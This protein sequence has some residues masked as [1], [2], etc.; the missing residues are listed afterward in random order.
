MTLSSLQSTQKKKTLKGY[1]ITILALTFFYAVICV[2]ISIVTQT[3]AVVIDSM[4]PVIWETLMQIL[5]Y[6]FYW[7]SFAYL[8]YFIFS[9]G[10]G[11]CKDFFVAYGLTV[12][13]RYG[14]NQFVTSSLYGF[15][16]VDEFVSNSLGEMV[17]FIIMDI[18]QMAIAVWIAYLLARH[19]LVLKHFMPFKKLF[20]F[21]NPLIKTA[22]KLALIP[23]VIML[24][25][26]SIYDLGYVM[27]LPEGVAV[28]VGILGILA[29]YLLDL[30][31]AFIGH[32][33]ILLLLNKF[34]MRDEKARFLAE[35][36]DKGL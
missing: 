26:R 14:L 6:V 10:I 13:L 15:P 25:Q 12:C 7:I 28:T 20:D 21:G 22:F 17:F 23:A 36:E 16:S 33:V 27:A 2:P 30:L 29:F 31:C 1:W 18:I 9:F 35:S 32:F 11:E 34:F 5:N 3:N 24:L 19:G 4:L 8:M